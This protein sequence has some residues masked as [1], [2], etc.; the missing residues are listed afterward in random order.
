MDQKTYPR[1]K[2]RFKIGIVPALILLISITI[3][4]CLVYAFLTN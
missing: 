3:S 2:K 1:V 4:A